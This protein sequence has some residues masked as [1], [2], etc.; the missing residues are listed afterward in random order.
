MI[1]ILQGVVGS[2]AYGLATPESD[3]DLL[4]VHVEPTKDVLGFGISKSRQTLTT[5]KPDTTSH[6]IGKYV[7]LA[8]R[9]NPTILEA[10]WLTSHTVL[11]EVGKE[12]VDLR[13]HFLSEKFVKSAYIGYAMQQ[14]KRL[15]AREEKGKAGFG[16]VPANRTAKHGRHC[17]RLLLQAQQLLTQETLTVRLDDRQ[18][19]V[20]REMGAWAERDP[21]AFSAAAQNTAHALDVTPTHL[22]D[23]PETETIE[24]WLVS[25]RVRE[26]YG[27]V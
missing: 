14:A 5:S 15:A 21:Q 9:C 26:P 7:S 25:V 17:Y 18:V 13:Y 22:F 23:A 6:E 16:D 4:A 11:T 8:L 27:L 19:D 3:V 2:Q 24:R 1:M 10:M 20:V 12:L